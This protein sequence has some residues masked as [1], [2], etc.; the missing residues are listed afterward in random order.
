MSKISK[1]FWNK[2]LNANELEKVEL[3]KTLTLPSQKVEPKSLHEHHCA[4]LLNSYL[5]D[6]VDAER[7]RIAN[8]FASKG[9]PWMDINISYSTAKEIEKKL[10]EC[11]ET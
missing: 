6:A 2:W 1:K 11:L 7:S 3:V 8:L 9:Q 10:E 4:T 5:V